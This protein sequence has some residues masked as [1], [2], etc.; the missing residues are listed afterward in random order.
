MK[1]HNVSSGANSFV[2]VTP[3]RVVL[4]NLT[5][6]QLIKK[7]PVCME[8]EGLLPRSQEPATGPCHEPDVFI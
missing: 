8:L 7:F 5:V 3:R 1:Q 6:T 2:F 4:E